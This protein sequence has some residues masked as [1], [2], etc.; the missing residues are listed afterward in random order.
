MKLRR[1]LLIVRKNVYAELENSNRL[2]HEEHT[3]SLRQVRRELRSRGIEV[4]ERTQTPS[5]PVKNVDLVITVGGDGTLLNASHAVRGKTP[6]LGVNSAPTTSVGFLT[7]CRAPTFAETLDAMIAKV[8]K[9]IEVHRIRVRL[10]GKILP[11][12]VLNDVLFCHDN[13]AI[14]SRYKLSVPEG[15]EVQKSSGVWIST[16]AGST[17]ALRSAGGSPLSLTAKA[18]AYIVREPYAPPG[19]AVRFL[20]EVLE[21][22]QDLTI[23]SRITSSS[24]FLDGS[25]RRY[26]VRYGERVSFSLHPQPLLLFRPKKSF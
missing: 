8:L 24:I 6:V 23:E 17:A 9:P 25:H 1:V 5:K 20:G 3:A 14:T 15:S 12:P 22:D 16:P 21:P 7:G 4:S 13:P 19:S 11:E 26:R 10:G 18:F 2:Q